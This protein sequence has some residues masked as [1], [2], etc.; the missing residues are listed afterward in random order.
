MSPSRLPILLLPPSL[1]P[2][3]LHLVSGRPG[4]LCGPHIPLHHRGPVG[5]V[6]DGD[7]CCVPHLGLP[8][9]RGTD[10]PG[11][12]AEIEVAVG[13]QTFSEQLQVLSVQVFPC[14]ANLSDLI[15]RACLHN[16][17]LCVHA[18]F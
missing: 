13:P 8:T 7:M 3:P 6:Y 5:G 16:T 9:L 10:I 14:A 18:G 11:G 4:E 1:L 12:W 2:R 15:D 17:C